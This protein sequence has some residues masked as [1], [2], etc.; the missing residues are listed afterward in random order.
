PVKEVSEES[1]REKNIRHGH[2]STLHIW[3]ARRPL[4]SSRAS[5]YAALTPE[6]RDEEER[7]KRAHFIANLSKR[8]NSLNKNL[9][10]RAREEILKASDGKP[11]KVLDPFAGGGAIPLEALRLGCETYASDLNPVAV[12][13]LKCTLEYPQ[14][15]GRK[16]V[17]SNDLFGEKEIN[18]LLEDVKKWG[19]WILEE[20][21]KEIGQFYPEEKDGS[22]SVGYI[23]ARTVKCQNPACGA[24]IPLVRQTWL[25]RKD[26]K[27]VAYKIIPKGNNIEFEI[28]G[29]NSNSP[30]DFDPEVGTVSRAKVICPCCNSSLNDKETRKQFQDGK[31]GQRMIA[32]VLHYPNKQ[33]KTY[34][35]ATEKDMEIFRQAEK[36]LE[37]KRQE[38]FDKWG[39]DPVPDEPLPPKETLG[40]RVQ[41]YG[42]LKWGDLFN[43]RQKLALITFAEKVRQAHEKMLKE[44]TEEE[45]A[46]AVVSYLALCVDKIADY[47]N[48][49][50]QWRNNLETV[51]HTFAR[52][53]LPMLWDYVEG[54]PVTGA[55]G[56]WAGSVDWITKTIE[57]CSEGATPATVSQASATSLPYPDNYFDAVIT[58]PPYYD[59]VPY[60]Y[61][62]DFFYVWLKRTIGDLYPELFATPLTPKTE[63]IVAYS[64]G[65]GGF[66]SGKKF[67]EEMIAKAF[68]EI[69]RVLKPNGITC[70]VFAHKSTEAWET[71]INALLN[72][73]L[74]LTA[75]WPVHTEMKARLRASE[76]A[77]LASSIYMVCRKRTEKKTAYFNEIKPQI[78]VRIKE[79]LDQFW[80]EGIGGSDFFISAIGPAMEV[81]GKYE[82]VEKLSGEKVSAKELLEF[83]RK[84]VSEY[85]LTKI[86][87]SPQ[88]G[89]IDEETR[90]YLLWRWTYDSAKVH[91]D[92]ARKLAQA[93]GVEITE[94]WGNGFI[95]KEKEFISVA[96]A[97]G[98]GKNFLEKGKFESTID[99][100]HA[101]LLYWEQN[102]RK[103][104]SDLLEETG[105]LTN[106][107]FWQVAQAISEVLP[108]EDKEKQMLQGFLYGKESY[109]KAGAKVHRYQRTLFE[110]E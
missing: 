57:V 104:I 39:F 62:S 21:R 19:N 40:F 33:G 48:V 15:Y 9:I 92:D 30:I 24:E 37:K 6:P 83:V 51:G 50:C 79:K 93:V 10:E 65:E 3:W 103:A 88:L 54:N 68:R 28:V 70:I 56:T 26:K 76:S 55:S 85:A 13:I 87:K 2:I 14:K 12:L 107:A 82:S 36:Y 8:E 59:N 44:G 84:S 1:T 35:L 46:K 67:F 102:N 86:L 52:Q 5:I 110:E 25:A 94:Q 72:S 43:P 4:A 97:R 18:P 20:A 23:W 90:F 47:C 78:E 58:D 74:Y 98:R 77:A 106:N 99:V 64:Y 11:P 29:A 105:N 22:I 34:R 75:S 95:K 101:C 32:V 96:S 7:L 109:G 16:K 49:L 31:A 17:K 100:L 81:F 71:I 73:G 60:S 53:A 61:L 89:G 42:M 108:E 27:K 66:E 45:Y 91:F 69:Q 38:L 41:R 80:N 63:E